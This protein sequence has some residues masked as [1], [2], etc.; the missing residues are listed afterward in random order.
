MTTYKGI[1][2]ISRNTTSETTVNMMRQFV[3]RVDKQM[4]FQFREVKL[5]PKEL[6]I[7]EYL[8]CGDNVQPK[9]LSRNLVL[10]SYEISRALKNM[11]GQGIINMANRPGSKK[12]KLVA[13]TPKGL[14][15]AKEVCRKARNLHENALH[16]LNDSEYK[17][18]NTLLGKI[19]LP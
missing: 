7:L 1:I 5:T 17:I 14:L 12:D 8:R 18:L 11:K 9:E 16:N 15:L 19:F 13:L 3:G 10:E 6:K 4:L 2:A